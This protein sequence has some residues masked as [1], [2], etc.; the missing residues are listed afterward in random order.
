M[1]LRW[2]ARGARREHIRHI[3]L[4]KTTPG[5][6]IAMHCHL[7][8]QK[9]SSYSILQSLHWLLITYR[10]ERVQISPLQKMKIC[11]APLAERGRL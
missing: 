10:E 11:N 4:K 9:H 8:A 6:I 3:S 2:E 1:T 7:E 5:Y